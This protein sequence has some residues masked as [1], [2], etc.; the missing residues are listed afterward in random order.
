[1]TRKEVVDLI[2]LRLAGD[3]PS[4]DF[5]PFPEEINLWLNPALAD[6]MKR[7]YIEGVNIDGM[8]FV[9]DAF[10]V[11]VKGIALTKED[12]S[13]Y[14]VGLLPEMPLSLPR[15]YDV[16]S[17]YIETSDNKLS[18]S[19]VRVSPQ[20]IDFYKELPHPSNRV[21]FWFEGQKI[22]I[23]SFAPLDGQTARLRMAGSIDTTMTAVYPCP[24]DYLSF[25]MDS[26]IARY[27]QPVPKDESND[28]KNII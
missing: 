24:A 8:E 9:G 7:N 26:I 10:Y 25:V 4:Q 3:I 23:D 27:A 12:K 5:R 15:G 11:S 13:D 19:G 21:F 18:R 17:M 16:S 20:Q 14:Y 22:Y 6:A 28:G 1:M 2:R